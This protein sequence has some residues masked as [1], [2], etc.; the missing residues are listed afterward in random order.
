MKILVIGGAGYVGSN[1]LKKL[2]KNK[3]LK[4]TSLDNYF[5][6]T[7]TN[8]IEG[9][10]YIYGNSWEINELEK[11][12]L[13]FHFGEYSRVVPS[14]KDTLY[15]FKS[16]LYGT[17]KVIEQ[18]KKWKAKLIYSA[19]SSKFGNNEN[20]SPYSWVKAKIVELIKNYGKWFGLEYEICYFYN[21]Y[22]KN[23][24][25]KGNY[26]T[27]IGIFEQQYSEKKPLTV[28]Y[29]GKQ[30]RQFTHIDDITDALVLIIKQNKNHEWYLTAE[31]DYKIIDVA[32]MFS[33]NITIIPKKR[34][35]RYNVYKIKND[36]K[37]LLN[38]ETNHTL[39]NYIENF[40]NE[41]G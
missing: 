29:D 26:A 28:V 41:Q 33:K 32:K 19:S 21:V 27:V 30:T 12:D 37:Q 38:W 14:F 5:T 39:E 40:I 23:H 3:K 10:N 15:L 31:K 11:H 6:G 9:V 13:V 2:K 18:C 20:L 36:T 25:N 17:S 35:E 34:G 22:G 1:L 8:H 16:N 4:L 24:I 7:N